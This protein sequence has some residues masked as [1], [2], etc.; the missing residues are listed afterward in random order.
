MNLGFLKLTGCN[1]FTIGALKGMVKVRGTDSPWDLL[2]RNKLQSLE[3]SGYGTA[4]AVEDGDLF[5]D[6]LEYFSWDGKHLRNFLILMG[7]LSCSLHV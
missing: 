7:V 3:V 1:N 6:Y 4:L 2:Q 5:S